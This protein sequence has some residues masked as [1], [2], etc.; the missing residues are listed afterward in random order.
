LQLDAIQDQ[1]QLK[2]CQCNDHTRVCLRQLK[3][4]L[5]QPFMVNGKPINLPTKQL[6]LIA[7]PIDKNEHV[8]TQDLLV[9]FLFHQP[10]EPIERLAHMG[11]YPIQKISPV[12]MKGKHG[13]Q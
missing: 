2:G 12:I 9:H 5:L 1:T 13:L 6:H 11:G 10:A 8:T 3:R 4:P 7:P